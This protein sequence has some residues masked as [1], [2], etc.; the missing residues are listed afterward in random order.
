MDRVVQQK[1]KDIYLTASDIKKLFTTAAV[2]WVIEEAVPIHMFSKP[3][4]CNMFTPFNKNAPDF[5]KISGQYSIR[6]QVEIQGQ[7]AKAAS[8]LE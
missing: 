7:F 3:T 8:L 2:S 1:P 4:F 5:M 6:E